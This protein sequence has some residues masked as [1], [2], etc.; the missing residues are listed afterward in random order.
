MIDINDDYDYESF[1]LSVCLFHHHFKEQVI[2]S[3]IYNYFSHNV[4]EFRLTRDL[5]PSPN[6]AAPLQAI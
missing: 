3:K 6:P 5:S 4:N 1:L 2:I